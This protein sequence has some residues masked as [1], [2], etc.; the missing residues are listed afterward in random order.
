VATRAELQAFKE[1]IVREFH[2]AVEHIHK[3]LAGAKAD[4][5]ALLRDTTTDLDQRVDALERK[6]GIR[7]G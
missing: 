1:E 6:T 4:D 2:V 5:I 7:L 3:D